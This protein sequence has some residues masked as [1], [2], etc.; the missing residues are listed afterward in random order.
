M[1]VP[2]NSPRGR[3]RGERSQQQQSFFENK[4][5]SAML[6]TVVTLSDQLRNPDITYGMFQ[7]QLKGQL[8]QET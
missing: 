6:S 8:Y 4:R 3:I 7:R 5:I 1:Y 2:S